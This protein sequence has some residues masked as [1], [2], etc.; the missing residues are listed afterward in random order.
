V[1]D[2][3]TPR[4]DVAPEAVTLG[5]EVADDPSDDAINTESVN[6]GEEVAPHGGATPAGG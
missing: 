6:D 2:P 3:A 5:G 4:D 1:T